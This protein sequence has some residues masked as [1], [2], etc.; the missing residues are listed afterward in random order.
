MSYDELYLLYCDFSKKCLEIDRFYNTSRWIGIDISFKDV[1]IGFLSDSFPCV[2]SYDKEYT[3]EQS[4]VGAN[5]FAWDLVKVR[6]IEKE[7]QHYES[8][9]VENT[10]QAVI[11]I[12]E[13]YSDKEKEKIIEKAK[14]AGFDYV[15]LLYKSYAAAIAKHWKEKIPDEI[16]IAS[17]VFR[18]DSFEVSIITIK[19][20]VFYVKNRNV[21][22]GSFDNSAIKELCL[23][24]IKELELTHI[25]EVLIVGQKDFVT[26]DKPLIKAVRRAFRK[27]FGEE[28]NYVRG[29]EDL[30]AKGLAIYGNSLNEQDTFLFE[31]PKESGGCDD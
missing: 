16:T 22:S 3:D 17:C 15:Q 20:S 30:V 12:S 18:E 9:D 7:N 14:Q 5:Q 23:T 13:A 4:L 21:I 8:N 28:C 24:T 1:Y 2:I 31:M 27:L 29:H 11:G 25:D 10:V 6:R 19:D 26:K